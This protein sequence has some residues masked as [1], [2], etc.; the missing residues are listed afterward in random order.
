[1]NPTIKEYNEIW[2]KHGIGRGIYIWNQNFQ[3]CLEQS[4]NDRIELALEA[5]RQRQHEKPK[6]ST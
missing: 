5:W 2:E 6:I 1:M 4:Y 3:S